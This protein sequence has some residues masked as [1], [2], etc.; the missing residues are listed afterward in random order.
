M[1][2]LDVNRLLEELGLTEYEA[3]TLSALFRLREAEAPETSRIAQVP[4]TRVYDVLDRLTKRG[5]IIEIHGRPK[6]Y[7]AIDAATVFNTLL[8]E[9]KTQLNR[10][11]TKANKLR[12]LIGVGEGKAEINERVMKVKDKAD[13]VRILSQEI[14][15][16]K[17]SVIAFAPLGK[18]HSLLKNSIKNAAEKNIEIKLIGAISEEAKRLAKEYSE[19]GVNLK[20]FEHGMHA[21]ILDGKKVILGLS[22]FG[23]ESL[24][25]H[26]AIWPE[27]R[28]MADALQN[29]FNQIWKKAK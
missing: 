13:F 8:N 19:L 28:P 1:T 9:K 5:L 24:E 23:K 12:N 15:S 26:F 2:E 4:K 10:L 21:Y 22:D 3:K 25:Y 17:N 29:Y 18:E 7:R 14:D 6:K 27:N 11:E 20:D 16:A